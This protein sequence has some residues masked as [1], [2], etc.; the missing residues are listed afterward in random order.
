MP[1]YLKQIASN[2]ISPKLSLE[3]ESC[4]ESNIVC[5]FLTYSKMCLNAMIKEMGGT[6][7]IPMMTEHGTSLTNFNDYY[8]SGSDSKTREA[9]KEAV[10]HHQ[11][12]TKDIEGSLEACRIPAVFL[13][14]SATIKSISFLLS[15]SSIVKLLH[16]DFTLSIKPNLLW[17]NVVDTNYLKENITCF[18]RV[19]NS[20]AVSVAE[21]LVNKE[22]LS[23]TEDTSVYLDRYYRH[24][25]GIHAPTFDLKKLSKSI[26]SSINYQLR[27][28]T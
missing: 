20:L 28:L 17:I 16:N 6:D 12:L 21:P 25:T 10:I 19:T 14:E 13:G 4:I 11:S 7:F 5:G 22:D 18:D 8:Y 24:A 27:T 26:V 3:A 2:F 23:E 15:K 9:I 1:N